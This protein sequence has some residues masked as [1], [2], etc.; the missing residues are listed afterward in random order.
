MFGRKQ[1]QAVGQQR[2]AGRVAALALAAGLVVP[3]AFVA[4]TPST[5]GA[6]GANPLAPTIAQAVLF[7]DESAAD[8]YLVVTDASYE[9]L[10]PFGVYG[11]AYCLVNFLIVRQ[12]PCEPAL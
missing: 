10:G 12:Y 5:A 2:V 7:Y 3:G 4:L 6:Q 9:A 1:E 8:V 11:E